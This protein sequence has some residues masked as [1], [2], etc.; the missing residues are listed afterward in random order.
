M[1]GRAA[2]RGSGAGPPGA[3]AAGGG[4][5]ARARCS[6]M[7]AHGGESELG[8]PGGAGGSLAPAR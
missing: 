1:E 5:A 7:V 2:S 8:L 6:V 4:E 3:R